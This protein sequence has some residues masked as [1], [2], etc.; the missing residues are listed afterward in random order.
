MQN[1][2]RYSIIIVLGGLLFIPFLGQVHLFDWDEINFAECAREMIATKDYLRVQIDFQPFYQKPPLFIW[3][4]V[5]S[6][7]LFGINEFAARFPNA[8]TGI[9]TLCSIYYAGKRVI[10]EHMAGWW[11]LL[12]AASWLPHFYFKSGIIDPVFNLFIFLSFFQVHLLR[13]ADRKL[14]HALLGGI[15]LGLAVLTKGPVAI[16]VALLSFVVYMIVNKGLWGY[17]VKHLLLVAATALVTTSLWFGVE[18]IAHGWDFIREFISYQIRLFST[19]DADHGGPF[20]YHFIV[21]FFGC[22]PASMFLFQYTRK[23]STDNEY[24]RAFTR[25][26]W[27][28]FWVVLILFSIVKTKIVHYSSLCYFPLTY[29]AALQLQRLGAGEIKLKRRVVVLVLI[30]GFLL[31]LVVTV[32]PLAGIY[33]NALIPYIADPFAVGNLQA[34]VHWHMS[35]IMWGILY[36]AGIVTALLLMRRHFIRGMVVLCVTQVF[37]I[38][39]AVLHFTP[40]IE[41]YSQRA[42]IEFFK[43]LEGKDVYVHVLGYK[44]YAQ[45][46]YTK[47]EKPTNPKSYEEQWLLSGAIDKP[48]YFICK[49]TSADQYR[50]VPGM[51]DLGSRNGFTFFKRNPG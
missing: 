4:Q 5:L 20:I 31:A 22:F 23:R 27:I 46:F 15:F 8:L 26:M 28:L 3:M 43:G 38:Q 25:W 6:M 10:N 12:Y 18:V 34:D 39:I 7:K 11:V 35:E 40:K 21:L 36:F 29:L 49:V 37:I 1:L 45:L 13:Y 24:A 44:S 2:I 16:L 51:L 17:K 14:L 47:K 33:K 19:E 50:S 32:F 9:A 30:T 41:A 42:A 48:V